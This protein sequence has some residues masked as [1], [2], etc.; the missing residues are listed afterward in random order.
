VSF[1]PVANLIHIMPSTLAS[2]GTSRLNLV[3]MLEDIFLVLTQKEKEIIIKRFS[4]S[5]E[6]K[7]TLEKIGQHFSV[8]RERI[9]QI[10]KIALN[11]LRRTIDNTRFSDISKLAHEILTCNGELLLEDLL[12]SEIL[13]K[14]H[15]GAA[16]DGKIVKLVLAVNPDFNGSEKLNVFKPFWHLLSLSGKR[17]ESLSNTVHALLAKKKEVVELPVLIDEV[18]ETLGAEKVD[19]EKTLYSLLNIDVRLKVVDKNKVGLMSW[20]H[21]NPKSIR[22]KSY[23]VLKKHGKP[24]HF[25]EIANAITNAGF[26]KKVVTTQAVHNELIRDEMFVLVGRGLYGLKEWGYKRGTVA[27][28]IEDLLG[29]K[30]PL[31]KQEI[32]NGVLKQRQVKKGTISLNLQKNSKF[33]RVG[34]A[35]YALAA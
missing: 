9:R 35:M 1:G 24:M 19:N 2:S 33:Q 26:D 23:I 10:E 6:P 28:V 29:K 27:D 17:I 22:D 3:E 15:S 12:I 34:R 8:T 13:L 7:Q 16:V 20:R 32:I 18:Q 4:L 5:D 21:I 31:S 11:K 30:S 25:V 14:I